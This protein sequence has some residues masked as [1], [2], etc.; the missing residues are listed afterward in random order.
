MCS[1][2]L[3]STEPASSLPFSRRC[4]VTV[5]VGVLT[6]REEI[7]GTKMLENARALMA[8]LV[9]LSDFIICLR[10]QVARNAREF[11]GSLFAIFIPGE[12]LVAF[13]AVTTQPAAR[14]AAE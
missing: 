8:T 7:D 1:M 3:E 4:S 6:S 5:S 14:N 12:A 10:P 2:A 9:F 13:H 11:P